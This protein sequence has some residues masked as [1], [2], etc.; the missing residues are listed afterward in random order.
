MPFQADVSDTPVPVFKPFVCALFAAL[1]AASLPDTASSMVMTR[2][3]PAL[4]RGSH[5]TARL[6]ELI[7]VNDQGEAIMPYHKYQSFLPAAA[8]LALA[9]PQIAWAQDAAADATVQPAADAAVDAPEA[10]SAAVGDIIVTATKRA[11]SINKVGMSITAASADTLAQAGVVDTGDLAKIVPGFNFTPSSYGVPVFTLRGI[12]FYDTSL[13]APPAVSVYVDEA[14]LPYSI[15]T[16]GASLDL[17]RVEVLKGPQ[18]TLYGQNSTGGAINYIAGKPQDQFG[19]GGELSYGRF[20]ALTAE[21]H[22]TGPIADGVNARAAV[23]YVSQDN[24]QR[25]YTRD[26]GLG[27]KDLLIG[28]LLVDLEPA[29]GLK[30]RLNANGWRDKSDNQAY[31]F[32]RVL[33]NPATLPSALVNYPLAPKGNRPADWTPGYDYDRDNEYY[34]LASRVEYELGAVNLVSITS[35]QELDRESLVDADG[36][37]LRANEYATPGHLEI[38]SQELRLSG[39]AGDLFWLV[40]GNYQ[41]EKIADSLAATFSNIGVPFDGTDTRN[42]TKV[43]T[44]AVFGNLDYELGNATFHAGA[45][46]SDD[47]RKFAG[48]MYDNGSGQLAA[49]LSGIAT[50]RSG[51]TVTIA[52]GGC[53][54]LGADFLPAVYRDTLHEDNLSWRLGVDYELGVGKLL[55]VNV[56]RGYK[57]GAFPTS[58]ATYGIQFRPATQESVLAFETGFK[59]SLADRRLQLNGAAFYYDYTDKQFRGKII[60][61]VLG[62]LNALVNVPKSRVQGAELQVTWLPSDAFTLNLGGTY[63]GSKIKGSFQNFNAF[64]QPV[65]VSGEQFPLTPKWQ[66]SGDAEYRTAINDNLEGFVGG[67]FS[68]QSKQNSGLGELPDLAIDGYALFDAR[69]GVKSLDKTWRASLFVRNLTNKSYVTYVSSASPTL[70]AQLRGQ[71]R[72]YGLTLGFSY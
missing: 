54:S 51:Q 8:V 23:R 1:A 68:Y 56:S 49:L 40:G 65:N 72:T 63:V 44:Y 42:N 12:G 4:V 2:Q 5:A 50:A 53:A 18:G 36:T 30:I 6:P 28:R 7:M 38:F 37:T 59:L 47:R 10:S 17:E 71:P 62:A 24:W 64:G 66:L 60:D 55:Y 39:D 61:P 13:A 19:A 9:V 67:N 69:L 14:P 26:D 41:H 15:L 25:S 58:G 31:Q 35:W 52:P 70:L 27:K 34:Q 43:E 3:T 22:V 48:C 46:Y 33:V 11:E 20:N 29:D 32:L 16:T 57:A 21:G 45:R